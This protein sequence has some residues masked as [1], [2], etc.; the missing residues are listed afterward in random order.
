[1]EEELTGKV[2]G[3]AMEVHGTL[4][5]GFLESAYVQ[6]LAYEFSKAGLNFEREKALPV[7]YKDVVLESAF[8]ADFM[9]MEK[10]VVE[11]KAVETLSKAHHA[12]VLNYL[13][14]SGLRVGLLFNFGEASLKFKRFVS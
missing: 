12:Q 14:A 1:M 11:I 6:A 7:K 13:K 10:V 2:I 3:C 8:R 4:G 9:V 5:P